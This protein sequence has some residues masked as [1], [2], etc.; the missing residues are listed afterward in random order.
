[1]GNHDDGVGRLIDAVLQA[2]WG[3]LS[4]AQ[5]DY[6]LFELLVREGRI[7]LA[8]RDFDI[9][10][11]LRTTVTRARALRY[12]YEQ[13]TLQGGGEVSTLISAQSFVFEGL[14]ERAVRV[15]FQSRYLREY[16][17]AALSRRGK[18]ARSELTA[19]TLVVPLVDFVAELV[20]L[21]SQGD[22]LD[23]PEGEAARLDLLR[24]L[25][26]LQ[27][28]DDAAS[29]LKSWWRAVTGVA[30]VSGGINDVLD[31]LGRAAS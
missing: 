11:T 20:D 12:R 30:T 6:L 15:Q 10:N 19:Q 31:S 28:S 8:D 14:P 7:D 16:M 26:A 25:A 2:P 24:Q 13:E 5:L 9:A 21:T 27:A 4:R 1:M 29:T 3:T 17:V 22:F 18:I 23:T